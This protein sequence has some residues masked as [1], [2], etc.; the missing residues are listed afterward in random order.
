MTTNE[1]AANMFGRNLCL[2]GEA[3]SPSGQLQRLP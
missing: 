1:F 2:G 3:A